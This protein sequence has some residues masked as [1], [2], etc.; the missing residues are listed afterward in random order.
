[1]W[2]WEHPLENDFYIAEEVTIKHKRPDLVLYI[3]GI[4]FA[5]I[6]LKRS[7][8]SMSEGIRQNLTNQRHDMIHACFC[9]HWAVLA[10][11]DSEGARYGTTG[12]P[13]KYYLSWKEDPN[14]KDDVS[15]KVRDQIEKYP[16]R[17]D[18]NL[19]SLCRKERFIELL[20][21]FIVFDSGV[22]KTCRPN[23]FF[24]NMAAR[25]F[26]RRHEGGIICT[27]KVPE[28]P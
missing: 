23:Q 9:N 21:N 18:K 24:G 11:N 26:V 13:E 22:E 4:A 19:I 1:M 25:D 7:T 6:E 2:D 27:P 5:V 10:G 17:L 12:T 3:N 28:N 8:V 14:A 20:H 15:V 16:L